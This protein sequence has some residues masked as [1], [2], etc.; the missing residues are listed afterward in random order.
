MKAQKLNLYF[1]AFMINS[2]NTFYL[3]YPVQLLHGRIWGNFLWSHFRWISLKRIILVLWISID[4]Y[5]L[6]YKLSTISL[7]TFQ[8]ILLKGKKKILFLLIESR[9]PHFVVLPKSL[10]QIKILCHLI[11]IFF[12]FCPDD[13]IFA[14]LNWSIM[15]LQL[16]TVFS[17]CRCSIL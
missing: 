14:L 9:K 4:K 12:Q 11:Y 16:S 13:F 6:S 8:K 3:L 10:E 17:D 15:N 2:L 5:I 7:C 1:F